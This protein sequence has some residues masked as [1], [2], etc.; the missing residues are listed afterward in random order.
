MDET[1]PGA[2]FPEQDLVGEPSIVINERCQILVSGQ[3]RIVMVL[4][5]A[6]TH[7]RADDRTGEAYA[8]QSLVS[9]GHARQGEVARAFGYSERSVRRHQRR[10]EQGGLAA[11]G[12]PSGYP[13]GRARLPASR[14]ADVERLKAEG[15]S[16][17]RIAARLGV[18]EKAIRKLLKRLGWRGERAQQP[19]LPGLEEDADP[20]LSM[21][22]GGGRLQ[23]PAGAS[24]ASRSQVRPPAGPADRNLS[25]GR[26]GLPEE[27]Q[28]AFLFSQDTD[29]HHRVVDRM[30]AY[31]GLISDALPLFASE[32]SIAGAGVL[33][34]L[35]VIHASGVLECA[36]EVY[37]SLGPAFHGLRTTILTFLIMSLLRIQHPEGLKEHSPQVLGRILG[38]DRAME[39]KTLR[40]KLA[41]LAARGRA[42][43][44]GQALARRRIETHGK[45][46]GFLY[47]DG[48]V[49]VYR[50]K[51][52]IPKTHVTRLRMAL[53][54]T[55]DYY[56]ND[57][58][59]DP[60]FV[61]TA[62]ANAGLTGM[63]PRIV[64]EAKDLLPSRRLT[65]VFDR[66]GY[67]FEL[68]RQL[69]ADGVDILTYRKGAH[70]PVPVASFR[71]HVVVYNGLAILYDLADQEVTLAEGL[72]LR[73]I[74][75]LCEGGHQTTILTSRRDLPASQVAYRMFERWRQENFFKYMREEF[76][77]DALVDYG[78]EAD[79]AS[80]EVPNPVWRERDAQLRKAT[81]ELETL[82]ARVGLE[83]LRAPENVRAVLK[84][85]KSR[86]AAGLPLEGDLREAVR[87]VAELQKARDAVPRRVPIA[88]VAKGEVI[89]LEC[90]RKHLT[91]VLKM[92]A[93]RIE[94]DLFERLQPFYARHEDE[95]RTLLQSAFQASADL[96][97]TPTE[98]RVTLAPMS[99]PH[100][101]KAIASLC[102]KLNET[103][104][105]YPG[106]RLILRLQIAGHPPKT[107][108]V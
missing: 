9:L 53:P 81:A 87:R 98:L 24:S 90:E 10:F 94:S 89:K 51:K 11:L 85:R 65:V 29:P 84:A 39:V 91:T 37:G 13:V 59:G 43:A 49:R 46:L 8:M 102:Q 7:F 5:V 54:A 28:G 60:L 71:E 64:S 108:Q 35:P 61:V 15:Y 42:T 72:T 75:V 66:G 69:L 100:R 4:G 106:T 99:S 12:R 30:L 23:T 41:Q 16:N 67:S 20:N 27:A 57:E 78:A 14:V 26:P 97:V 6:T 21:E 93:Y 77:I 34:A 103:P 73:Q 82:C 32:T 55:T 104:V 92:T 70:E 96:E 58:R 25:E 107:G 105:R 22:A 2:L 86:T 31:Q 17:R 88:H 18:D 95:G 79:D 68:F 3:D 101:T 1:R 19:R 36:E 76:A 40:A 48:H 33:L 50:G 56:V 80:R 44:F 74:T 45:A 47:V 63:L 83:S 62:P 38:L 52:D